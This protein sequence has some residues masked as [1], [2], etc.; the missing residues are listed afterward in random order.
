MTSAPAPSDLSGMS[1]LVVEDEYYLAADV[2]QQVTRAGGLVIGPFASAHDGLAGLTDNTPDCA[3]VD[4]NT[5]EGP[6]FVLA[7]ALLAQGVP[8]AFLTG[9]DAGTVPDRFRGIDRIE[10]PAHDRSVIA[11]LSKLRAC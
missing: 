8:F 4:I 6:S 10:K 7:D 11:V 9:Y 5:G 3:L 1:V 2:A